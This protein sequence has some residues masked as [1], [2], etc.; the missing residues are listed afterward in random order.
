MKKVKLFLTALSVVA[1]VES[2]L[3]VNANFF[4]QGSV[5]CNA[6]Y[7]I[8]T[9]FR[10]NQSNL[11]TTITNYFRVYAI[12]NADA[13]YG[14]E[15]SFI[16]PKGLATI[17]TAAIRSI[18]PLS[19]K[20]GGDIINDGGATITA[21]GVCWSTSA[22]PTTPNFKTSDSPGVG[23][24]TS[25][26]TPLASQSTYFVRAYATNNYG[27]AFG[28]DVS[29][30]TGLINSVVD[31]DGNIYPYVVIG[32]QTWMASNLRTS[33]FNNGDPITNGLSEFDWWKNSSFGGGTIPAFT[34]PNGD[35]S[36]NAAYGKLYNTNVLIDRRNACPT[37][38]H[39]ST[40]NDWD[41]LLVNLGMSQSDIDNGKPGNIGAKLLEGGSSG[42]NLKKAGELDIQNIYG[43]NS[44]QYNNFQLWGLY[45]TPTLRFGS[46]YYLIFNGPVGPDGIYIALTNNNAGAV[47]CVKD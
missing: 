28:N 19:T 37:G 43:V 5:Y 40:F 11:M 25:T 21:R 1:T 23:V 24:F 46:Y 7:A 31:I 3:A 18:A 13:A 32:N 20:S 35:S 29:I 27:T 33:H 16:T 2:A 9:N 14:N 26:L 30:T 22:H 44:K 38:W 47:R 12:N 45:L 15:V 8:G 41:T 4:R 6:N 39:V 34:F 42:L 10:N 17:T 36:T